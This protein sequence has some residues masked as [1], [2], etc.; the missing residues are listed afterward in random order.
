MSSGVKSVTF[1]PRSSGIRGSCPNERPVI[2]D[3]GDAN[4]ISN[5]SG[6][7]TDLQKSK[8]GCQTAEVEVAEDE[9]VTALVLLVRA[10]V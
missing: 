1:V 4:E 2:H 8:G 3:R 7:K 10:H 9:K 6:R 5:I